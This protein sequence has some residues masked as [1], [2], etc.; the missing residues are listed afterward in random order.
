MKKI[1]AAAF[2]LGL[3]VVTQANDADAQG[4]A[5]LTQVSPTLAKFI[6]TKIQG[7][8]TVPAQFSGSGYG[9]ASSLNGFSC[10]NLV[11]SAQSQ[12]MVP[13]TNGGFAVTH[14]WTRSTTA[15]GNWSSGKC[16]YVL[17]VKPDSNFGLVAGSMGTWN[18]DQISMPLAN[19]PS[20]QKVPKGTTK[21]DNFTITKVE[22]VVIG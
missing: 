16:S 13:P 19:T 14:V 21:V 1:I 18:C 8:I 9:S 7:E 3:A 12:E 10:S 22:C 4:T 15:T 2:V 6:G 20:V 5:Q 11:I 17:Y